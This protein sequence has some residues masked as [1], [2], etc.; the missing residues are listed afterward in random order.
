MSEEKPKLRG[1]DLTQAIEQGLLVG[2]TV[3]CPWFD[4]RTGEALGVPA[5]DPVSRWRVEAVRETV[6]GG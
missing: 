2:D 4:L 5:L 3:R 1:P 6:S